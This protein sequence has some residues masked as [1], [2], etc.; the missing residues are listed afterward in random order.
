MRTSHR[1]RSGQLSPTM[2][3]NQLDQNIPVSW[4]VKEASSGKVGGNVSRPDV[5]IA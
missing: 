5:R 4:H 2:T 1:R 3:Y